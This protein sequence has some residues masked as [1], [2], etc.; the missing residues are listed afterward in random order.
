[1]EELICIGDFIIQQLPYYVRFTVDMIVAKP[2]LYKED[3][4]AT[5]YQ[6]INQLNPQY[7]QQQYVLNA[8]Q[9]VE[10]ADKDKLVFSYVGQSAPDFQNIL[11]V[12]IADNHIRIEYLE[13]RHDNLLLPNNGHFIAALICLI[14]TIG[15]LSNNFSQCK[16]DINYMVETNARVAYHPAHCHFNV[17]MVAASTYFAID[18]TEIPAHIEKEDAIYNSIRRF[19]HIYKSESLCT[20]PYIGLDKTQFEKDYAKLWQS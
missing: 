8:F 4:H 11:K 9:N 5:L 10:V 1:M 2:T 16:M 3:V 14:E 17:L 6:V 7:L 18:K 15:R 12:G 19:F 13:L 20:I